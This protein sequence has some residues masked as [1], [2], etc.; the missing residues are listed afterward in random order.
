MKRLLIAV[1]TLTLAPGCVRQDRFRYVRLQP[2]CFGG[3]NATD[4]VPGKPDERRD[5]PSLDCRHKDFSVGFIEFDK[6]GRPIDP[7]QAE[8]AVA[9]IQQKKRT[10]PGGKIITL[11]YIHGWK[12]NAAQ[13]LPGR[14]WQ[15][16]ERFESALAELAYRSYVQRGRNREGVPIVGVYIGWP[17]KSLMGPGW[18]TFLSFWGRRNTANNVGDGDPLAS[19]LNRVIETTNAD[20]QESRVMLVGHSF[21]ARVLEHAIATGNVQLFDERSGATPPRVDLTLYVNSA[22]DA[23]L[24]LAMVEKLKQQPR[25][26]RHPDFDT[27]DCAN[28]SKAAACRAYPILVAI[29]SRGDL[30][31]KYLLPT[32]NTLNGDTLRPGLEPQGPSGTF[33][34]RIPPP[35]AYKRAAAG[36]MPF[37]QSHMVRE[38]SCE[39]QASSPQGKL[40]PACS[41]DDARCQFAFRTLG[42]SPS[43]YQVDSRTVTREGTAVSPPPFNS[44]A[45]W[46]MA[47]DKPVINDHGDIWNQSFL[48]MLGQLMAPRGFFEPGKG[49]MQLRSDA[50]VQ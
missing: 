10:A 49:R 30:A 43:C 13:A 33:A 31:T 28:G 45:Y 19:T 47:V 40:F 4:P 39:S 37:M 15:D 38:V 3:R 42:E 50:P 5:W 46:I 11:V 2:S 20:S 16:V 23:R 22:N 18:F 21:G 27:T 7:D 24:S 32:A 35:A 41:A 25:V 12:N 48:Q 26:V 17:G 9:L 36:H 29:T 44:T 14:K 1:V 34:D 8:K 6:H